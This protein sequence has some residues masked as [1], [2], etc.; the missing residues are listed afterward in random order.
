MKIE[1]N[2]GLLYKREYL[3]FLIELL[4]EKAI[5]K[6]ALDVIPNKI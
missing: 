1:R 6:R 4:I 5:M 3:F 2:F